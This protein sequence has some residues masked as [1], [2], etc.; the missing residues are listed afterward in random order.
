MHHSYFLGSE[1]SD[2][3]T[4]PLI[5]RIA[6]L[7][8]AGAGEQGRGFAVV[9]TEVRNLAQRSAAAA[10][11]VMAL[12]DDSVHNIKLGTVLVEQAGRTISTLVGN[13]HQVTQIVSEIAAA[14][15][16]HSEGIDQVNQAIAQMGHVT[17]Q[18]AALVEEAAAATQSLRKQASELKQTVEVFKINT[19]STQSR[20]RRPGNLMALLQS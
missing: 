15:H 17:Q 7:E 1:A 16:E 10:K 14:S 6:S 13:V 11:E 2:C 12:I 20:L 18:S 8:A 9:E 19:T 5:L 3:R 4:T